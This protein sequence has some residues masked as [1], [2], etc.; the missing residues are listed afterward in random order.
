MVTTLKTVI[1]SERPAPKQVRAALEKY[2]SLLCATLDSTADGILVVDNQGKVVSFNKRFVEMYRIPDEVLESRDCNLVLAFVLEQLKAPQWFQ[3]QIIDNNSQ[4]DEPSCDLLEFNDG[5]YFELYSHP[6]RIEGRIVGRAI[7]FRDITEKKLAE[8][9]LQRANDEL[10]MRV[11]ERTAKLRQANEQLR[12]EIAELRKAEAELKEQIASDRAM[13]SRIAELNADIG[14]ELRNSEQRFRFLGEIIPQQVWTA[15]P[16]GRINYVNQRVLD[17][18]D[19]TVEEMV[20][21]RWQ[22]VVHPDDLPQCN[23]RWSHALATGEPYEIEFRLKRAADETYRWHIGRALPLHNQ[24]GSIVAWFGTCTDIDEQ[25]Q[26]EAALKLA[27]EDLEI[28][29]RD[30]TAELQDSEAKYRSVVDNVKEVIF[31]TDT[32]GLWT[33]LNPAWTEITG[34]SVKESIG[35]NFIN[36][37]HP[38]DQKAFS[39]LTACMLDYDSIDQHKSEKIKYSCREEIRCLTNEGSYRYLEVFAH[40]TKNADGSIIGTSGT[41]TDITERKQ[42]EIEIRKTLE[43]EKELNE[44]K[45]RFL[46]MASHD[47]RTPL[48]TI[49][50]ASDLL[51]TFG[52]QLSE[53]KKLQQLNKIQAAVKN[54]NQLLEDVLFIGKAESGKFELKP[55]MLNLE[56]F[57][58]DV[59]SEIEITDR[60]KHTFVFNCNRQCLQGE[61]LLFEIDQK[62]IRQMLIN[63]LSNAAKY[64]PQGSMVYFNLTCQDEKAIFQIR[65][66]GIGI[67]EAD[68]SRLFEVFHRASNVGNISGTGLGMAI[69]KQAVDLHGGSITFESKVGVGTTF[70]VCLPTSQGKQD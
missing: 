68:Q 37:V 64:S 21:W 44:L 4:I 48:A 61:C 22:E 52:Y 57:C 31:Q 7:S 3:H 63:L 66:E 56:K 20:G 33:F 53:G 13:L 41:I 54:M 50:I 51:K 30:R 11:E 18:C 36:Y 10:E 32:S 2:H 65:D 19:R 38:A 34:F 69:V 1:F 58:G 43:K 15:L 42:A 27:K 39:T 23:E 8:E 45:S 29:V 28:K 25:K 47:F 12:Q 70:T 60:K 55:V 67:P 62:L 40:P 26:I 35:T 49:L 59:L 6:Q 14:A 24:E 17:Y 46:A 5:R 9:A 16:D